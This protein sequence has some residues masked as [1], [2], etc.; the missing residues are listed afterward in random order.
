MNL[1]KK[2]KLISF[3]LLLFFLCSF[4]H[5]FSQQQTA[6]EKRISEI[7]QK[8]FSICYYGYN[9][10]LTMSE[11]VQLQMLTSGEDA[12]NFI[13]GLGILNYAMN[14][15]ETETKT[16]TTQFNN[17]LNS[18]E[19]LKTKVDFQRE[20]ERKALQAQKKF[21]KSD[22]GRIR[23]KI[24][25]EFQ[26]WNQKGEFEKQGDYDLR[27]QTHSK[28]K[29]TEI[30]INA[31]K[32]E[33]DEYFNNYSSSLKIQL[34]KYDSENE[35]FPISFKFNGK[36]WQ[37]KLKI[38]INNA[39]NFKS[40]WGNLNW[41][42]NYYDWC[43]VENSLCP[44]LVI[45]ESIDE[46]T[47]YKFPVII[48]NQSDIIYHFDDFEI[49]NSY[50]KGFVFKYSDTKIIVEEQIMKQQLLD[51][52]ETEKIIQK[53]DSVFELYN[54]QLLQ[55]PYNLTKKTMPNY[56]KTGLIKANETDYYRSLNNIKY[57]FEMLNKNMEQELKT[58][59]PSEYC[60]IFY[61]KN[62]DKKAKADKM[63]IE[64]KC[65]YPQRVNFD[66]KFISENIND[67]GCRSNE[68]VINRKLFASKAEFDFFYDKGD[69]VL[70]T[71]IATRIVKR[72]EEK[73]ISEFKTNVS[74]IEI[75]NF[76]DINGGDT[77]SSILD[78]LTIGNNPNNINK[79]E[80][81]KYYVQK[82]SIYKDKSYYSNIIDFIIDANKG[83]KKEWIKKGEL[84]VDKIEFYEAYVSGNYKQIL[85]NK[86]QK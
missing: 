45:L 67:C 83:L 11:K 46:N 26:S 18:A 75:L 25:S 64:C 86:K 43:L 15:T 31:I 16:L 69:E 61:L 78:E 12:R 33:V 85:K 53:L 44:T 3:G 1:Q 84:F 63:Y 24:K 66:L 80:L 2:H 7:T 14:H 77:G 34:L 10:Q 48:T 39:E 13:L 42:K 32:N 4:N 6:Y 82:I 70:K 37:N 76:K 55:N 38:P 47:Q 60:R 73:A 71:E 50:L 22:A 29:Y 52:L 62:T 65:I 36:E 54:L 5:L 41:K 68:Y 9:K 79:E 21:D 49:F 57:D 58:Q 19:K 51:S 30:C 8:Y 27:L 59:N 20:K 72:E 81:T 28:E 56:D 23:L 40:N 35:Y 74:T 17:E